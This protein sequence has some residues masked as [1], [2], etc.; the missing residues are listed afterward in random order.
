[1]TSPRPYLSV[2]ALAATLLATPA[3]AQAPETYNFPQ[4]HDSVFG[5]NL[6]LGN[7]KWYQQGQGAHGRRTASGFDTLDAFGFTLL[8]NES[9]IFAGTSMTLD[10]YINDHF[11]GN[12]GL[13]PQ[14]QCNSVAGPIQGTFDLSSNPI[15]GL[16]TGKEFDIRFQLTG[17][18]TPPCCNLFVFYNIDTNNSTIAM[19]GHMSAGSGGGG[20]NDGGGSGGGGGGG[21]GGTIDDTAILNRIGQAESNLSG[22]IATEGT[23]TRSAVQQVKD[24]LGIVEGNVNASI[25]SAVLHVN[26]ETAVGIDK[27]AAQLGIATSDL[28]FAIKGNGDATA[29]VQQAIENRLLPEVLKAN[30]GIAITQDSVQK[31]GNNFLEQMLSAGTGILSVW[32]GGALLPVAGFVQQSIMSVV[33]GALRPDRIV[34]KAMAE[35]NRGLKRIKKLFSFN[36]PAFALPWG[37]RAALEA[38]TFGM[39]AESVTVDIPEFAVDPKYDQMLGPDKEEDNAF[40]AFIWFQRAYQ[41]L[42]RPEGNNGNHYG[43]GHDPNDGHEPDRASWARERDDWERLKAQYDLDRAAW[44]KEKADLQKQIK[45]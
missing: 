12:V 18:S 10:V 25:A 5:D 11:V 16:G 43:W 35:F 2:L 39:A 4:E 38:M 9:C 24:A 14:I 37:D 36:G 45:K 3:A 42:V 17:S 23:T 22:S 20:G 15:A 30:Q 8:L 31:I 27:L 7:F 41:T 21:G 29:K 19:A 26:A 33:N 13:P 28:S 1:M 34:N 40:G 32:S 6:F 44:A